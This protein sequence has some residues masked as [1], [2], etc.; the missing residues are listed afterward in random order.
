MIHWYIETWMHWYIETLIHWENLLSRKHFPFEA[1]IGC[2]RRNLSSI[3][4]HQYL[5]FCNFVKCLFLSIGNKIANTTSVKSLQ[6]QMS[7][8]HCLQFKK[9]TRFIF[10]ASSWLFLSWNYIYHSSWSKCYFFLSDDDTLSVNVSL[11]L[12]KV[13]LFLSDEDTL[14]VNVSLVLVKV[15]LF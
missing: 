11:V 15:L 9:K 7:K 8:A 1:E 3:W 12:V 5:M 14:S 10:S 6:I 4:L 13:L 2:L